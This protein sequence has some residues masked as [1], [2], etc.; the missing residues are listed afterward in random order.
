MREFEAKNVAGVPALQP[1][2]DDGRGRPFYSARL[3]GGSGAREDLLAS[4][5]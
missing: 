3:S 2:I 5:N 4:G 1:L